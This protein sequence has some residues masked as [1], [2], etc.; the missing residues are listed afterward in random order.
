M[1]DDQRKSAESFLLGIKHGV[2]IITNDTCEICEAYK[3]EIEYINN[4][5]LYFVE[6]VTDSEKNAIYQLTQ[7]TAFPIT[8]GFLENEIEFVRLGQLFG[9]DLDY[10]LNFLNNNFKN[11]PLNESDQQKLV[12][13]IKN[14]TY[15]TYY[16]FPE[17][18]DE[19]KKISIMSDSIKNKEFPIDVDSLNN[20]NMS[21]D[22]KMLMITSNAKFTKLVIFDLEITDNYSTLSRNVIHEYITNKKLEFERRST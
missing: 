16:V 7:R 20:L 13:R 11:S 5:N 10:V 12:S 18:T 19:N 1:F 4:Y 21:D 22:D 14:K 2:Y 8:V 15:F 3:K 17:N 6:A 9:E